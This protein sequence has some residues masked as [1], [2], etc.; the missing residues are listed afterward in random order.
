MTLSRVLHLP[1]SGAERGDIGGLP[2]PQAGSPKPRLGAAAP[3][4]PALTR[5]K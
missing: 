3:K 4:N 2:A 5:N 1:F